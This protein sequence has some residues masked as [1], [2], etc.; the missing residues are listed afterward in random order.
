MYDP[1][2]LMAHSVRERTM[3]AVARELNKGYAPVYLT[4]KLSASSILA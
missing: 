2:L 1:L 4:G 3:A